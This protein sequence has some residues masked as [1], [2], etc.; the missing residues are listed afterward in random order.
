MSL[1]AVPTAMIP[2]A[3]RYAPRHL[4]ERVLRQRGSIEGEHKEVT[5]L[6]A[7]VK[8]SMDLAAAVDAEE[9]HTIL[10]RFFSVMSDGVHRFEGC[11]NQFTGDGIMAL[12]GAP[13]ALED[14]ARHA[15]F[16]ALALRDAVREF[17]RE[18]R[19][20]RGLD[21]AVRFGLNSGG[22]IVGSIGD[23]L[24]MDYTAQGQVVNLAA[25]MEQ[26][27]EAGSIYLAPAT[28]ALVADYFDLQD[29]GV[30]QVKGMT[31]GVHVRELCGTGGLRTRLDVS[32]ARGLSRFVGRSAE[33]DGLE[34]ATAAAAGGRVRVVAAAGQG[35]SRLCHE[36]LA[37]RQASGAAVFVAVGLS[38]AWMIPSV[39]VQQL[40]RAVLG[41][42][43]GERGA[44]VRDR[45]AGRILLLGE[46]FRHHASVVCDLLGLDAEAAGVTLERDIRQQRLLEVLLRL[47]QSAAERSEVVLY[48]DDLHWF[49]PSSEAFARALFSAERPANVSVIVA[50]RPDYDGEWM[51]AAGFAA[52]RLD[53]LGADAMRELLIGLLG[54]S[55]TL[56]DMV[57]EIAERTA[58]NPFFAEEVVRTLVESGRLRGAAGRYTAEERVVV[59]IPASVHAVLAARID[60]LSDASK[61]VLQAAAVI[62][63]RFSRAVLAATCA[64]EPAELDSAVEDLIERG[65]VHAVDRYPAFAYSFEH[66]LTQEVAEKTL[67]ASRRRALHAEVAGAIETEDASRGDESAALIA[68]H[69]EAADEPLHAAAW[70]RRA[71][72][73]S[74]GGD[75]QQTYG[76]WRRVRELVPAD[77]DDAKALALRLMAC[78]ELLGIS[79][80]VGVLSAQLAEIRAEGSAAAHRLGRTV[81]LAAVES[82]FALARAVDGD[83]IDAL[84]ILSE[85]RPLAEAGDDVES[86]MDFA[87]TASH[88]FS[89]S[90]NCLDQIAVCDLGLGGLERDATRGEAAGAWLRVMRGDGLVSAGRL[91]EGDREIRRGLALASRARD[92][93]VRGFAMVSLCRLHTIAGRYADADRAA[94]DAIAIGR[95]TGSIGVWGTATTLR[96]GV[97]VAARRWNEAIE[98]L[99]PM[100]QYLEDAGVVLFR[101]F[102]LTQLSMSLCGIGD[103]AQ[104][105][106]VAADAIQQAERS[107]ARIFAVLGHLAMAHA[108]TLSRDTAAAGRHLDQAE[109][110]VAELRLGSIL[111]D[112]YLGRVEI[113]RA[114]G[115]GEGT[116]RWRAMAVQSL[117]EIGATDRAAAI[118]A[119]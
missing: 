1:D 83:L 31:G 12:F 95:Q 49:D 85:A 2:D 26:L 77:T 8:G 104:G 34:R 106:R 58:G 6:F 108:L 101:I 119:G 54:D 113:S 42:D 111:A 109:A 63:R 68:M 55:P 27:A 115:D 43:E 72:R 69:W 23:D 32:R 92:I 64:M 84:Q 53:P 13:V 91:D 117:C 60:R 98:N 36:F 93:E 67:L 24:R 3:A 116:A 18:L 99:E 35:K 70:H 16:A 74:S 88:V 15:C 62:G 33:L 102:A 39:P 9:W 75:L 81:A 90:G 80:R 22:V 48:L 76:H 96:A 59:E 87:L 107:G 10:D 19:R 14:H 52:I 38:H 112:V 89:W 71:A 47:V 50:H 21:F 25:R 17:G 30:F 57:A 78:R 29:L 56:A 4:A 28:A 82:S 5:I 7:D 110:E 44:P 118:V 51:D 97:F 66:P 103:V 65:F 45:V 100:V 86:L 73:W 114:E 79:T 41:I 40:F 11:I 46:A 105:A 61:S 94:Q 37:R 20:E